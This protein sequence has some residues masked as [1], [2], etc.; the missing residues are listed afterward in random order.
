MLYTGGDDKVFRLLVLQDQPHTLHIILCIAP[1]AQRIHIAQVQAILQTL[2][3][4][5]RSQ[6]NLTGNESLAPALALM[7]EKD[8]RAAEHAISLTVFLHNP[9]SIQLGHCIGAIRMER[10][11]LVLGHLLY[12]AVKFR[13]GSLIDTAGLF[14]TTGT[15]G[16]QHTQHARSVH[17]CREL[18]RVKA[19]L[20]MT[21]CCQI[22]YFVRAHQAHHLYQR[23]GIAQVTIVEVE[24]LPSLQVGNTFTVVHRR[25]ADDSVYLIT[26]LQKE[27]TQV[28][29]ILACHTSYQCFSHYVSFNNLYK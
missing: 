17:V 26:L 12:L 11:V 1:V 29:T 16:L 2:R 13:G 22:V 7:I 24:V 9:E 28:T 3:Y 8:T 5:C 18:G 15:H 4:A 10:R 20:Y 27:L 6:R 23:H 25:T 14:Q 21:L 19:Y